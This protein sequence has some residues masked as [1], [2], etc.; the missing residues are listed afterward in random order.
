MQS[1]V[2]FLG[3]GKPFQGD[4]HAALRSASGHTRVIDWLLHATSSRGPDVHFV[5]G[6]K[7]DSIK[8]QYPDFNYWINTDWQVTQSAYSLLQVDLTDK[9]RSLVSYSDILF[10]RSLIDAMIESQA[11]ISVAV[12]SHWRTRYAGRT[13]SDLERSEKVCLFGQT[14]TRLG[15]DIPCSI[16]SAEF[17][18]CVHFGPRAVQYLQISKADLQQRFQ[19][20]HLSDLVEALRCQ[21]MNVQ[22]VDVQGDWAELNE[23]QDLA[24]F[25][26][27]TKAQTLRR[28]RRMVKLSRIEDQVSFTV[29][30]WRKTADSLIGTIQQSFPDQH[31]AIRSSAL[32]E[33]GFV[34]SNAGAYT[35]LLNI[36]GRDSTRLKEAIER[37]ISSYSDTNP[38]NQVLVQPMLEK[39]LASGVA[40]TRSL[41]SGSPYYVINY[42][43][44]SGSTES[45][46]S[47][48]SH[49][50]KTLV[51]RRDADAHSSNIPKSLQS[52]LPA[53]REIESLLGYDSLD[54]EFAITA[55]AG[56][57]ILQV[58]P[59]AV[60]HSKWDGSDQDIL[61][62]LDDARESFNQLQRPA[63]FVVGQRALFGIMPDWNPA[64]IIGTKPPPLSVSLY[65]YLIMDETWA[66]QRA[67][68]GYRDVRPQPLLVSFAGHPYVDIRASF[69]SFIPKC[70][71]DALA[72]RLIDFYLS[73]LEHNPHL[74]DKV[75]F[76]VVPTCFA[77]DFDRW[78]QRLISDGGF[79]YHEIEQLRDAL[80]DISQSALARNKQDLAVIESLERRFA[81]LASSSAAPLE[82]VWTLLHDCRRYGALPFAHLARSAFV[83]VTFLRSAVSTGTLTDRE[84]DDF[85]GTIS[86]V[87][88]TFTHD[89]LSCSKGEISSED[90]M[91]KYGHLRPGTYDINSLSYRAAPERYLIPIVKSATSQPSSPQVNGQLWQQARQRFTSALNE[92]GIACNSDE[93]ELFLREAIEGRE[94]AK[95][96]FTRNLSLALDALV[97][98]AEPLGITRED[99][100]YIEIHKLMALRNSTLSPQEL[101]QS[102]LAHAAQG[103]IEHEQIQVI[104]LPP[105]LC[106][107]EDFNV[108]LYP[109]TQPNFVGTGV[110]RSTCVD[111]SQ[112]ADEQD[113]VG[114][115][116]MIPQADPGYDWLF[117][118]QI[119]GL[120]TMY[121]GA[122]S[123]MAIRAAE[124]GL[125]AALGIGEAQYRSLA[126]AHSLELDAGNRAIRVVR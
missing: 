14:I 4:E 115:I 71:D 121:G 95:F 28:L 23:P 117:G 56:L 105:L 40:F 116:A 77:L 93:L 103:K 60:D 85:L 47:G 50:H 111:L 29:T 39:V 51:M 7:A 6:Y 61:K 70:L 25:V 5:G 58:R 94:Y 118:R 79:T 2:I 55:N 114:K 68:Y 13:R 120:I 82:Q 35:S 73:W 99:L 62:R 100:A 75:E 1:A 42:D 31:L 76:D 46:T 57:H 125:P 33:D 110:V 92:Q 109:A 43:D 53:L 122:N 119:G 80:R 30:Q 11:D 101:T 97:D 19:K 74:H 65:Q 108:F 18:G 37:V 124:F 54:I 98:W 27:G 87:S 12:D 91:Q 83:A 16:A 78:R 81:H 96:A 3:A 48:S 64:E 84:M 104:E 10:R 44:T 22:A 72:G 113:L 20:G 86:T 123:H 21:G 63:P 9:I 17:V 15:P 106:S 102:M 8:E 49:D 41:S 107:A 66:T 32:S 34:N 112:S 59:I 126:A 52:L 26:L 69:N 88:H 38:D 67:E 36:D 24:H 89:A 45:I 90:F